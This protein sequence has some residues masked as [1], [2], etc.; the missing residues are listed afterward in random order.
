MLCSPGTFAYLLIPFCCLEDRYCSASGSKVPGITGMGYSLGLLVLFCF[1]L[2]CGF[3]CF[4][5]VLYC[6]GSNPGV[7]L[8]HSYAVVAAVTIIG[9]S[10]FDP[11]LYF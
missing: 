10:S 11:G 4:G 3:F 6:W 8:C 2:L 5:L 9:L 7:L 1:V